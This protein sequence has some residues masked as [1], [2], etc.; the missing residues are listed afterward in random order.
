MAKRDSLKQIKE[1]QLQLQQKLNKEA[2]EAEGEPE[3]ITETPGKPNP[4]VPEKPVL[5]K[6]KNE[7]PANLINDEKK[8]KK[9]T[10]IG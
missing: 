5:P 9:N 2:E 8:N 4:A 7:N 3:V 1:A 10:R 6:K